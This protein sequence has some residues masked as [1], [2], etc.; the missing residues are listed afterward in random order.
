MGPPLMRAVKSER[1]DIMGKT[2]RERAGSELLRQS[3]ERVRDRTKL[4]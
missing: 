3:S 2:A 1:W 4:S